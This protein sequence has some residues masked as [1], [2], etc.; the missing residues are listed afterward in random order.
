MTHTQCSLLRLASFIWYIIQSS[1]LIASFLFCK[2]VNLFSISG[3]YNGCLP[4]LLF[5]HSG[6][7]H[8]YLFNSSCPAFL[9]LHLWHMEIHRLRS[10][11]RA[12]AAGPH[13]S[14][15]R[16]GSEP[17]SWPTPQLV[18]MPDPLTHWAR[19]G[20]KPTSSWVL[21]RFLT[22]WTTRGTPLQPFA[23]WLIVT[24][25][26]NSFPNSSKLVTLVIAAH[27]ILFSSW[28]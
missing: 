17:H 3:L 25:Q 2:C 20:I 8:T 5:P 6:P 13:H 26:R 15:S 12:A 27:D 1:S 10:W 14:H 16:A 21:V 9:G 24:A 7:L 11:I 18:T 22:H 19:P 23:C 28:Y 4:G